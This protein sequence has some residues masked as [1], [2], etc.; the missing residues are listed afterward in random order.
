MIVVV[1][2]DTPD[3]TALDDIRTPVTFAIS[4]TAKRQNNL[5]IF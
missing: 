4:A 5:R 2:A 3:E 1:V